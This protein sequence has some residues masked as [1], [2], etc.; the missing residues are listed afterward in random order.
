MRFHSHF[1]RWQ[2]LL[3]GA[4]LTCALLL[5]LRPKSSGALPKPEPLSFKTITAPNP[6][7]KWAT[8]GVLISAK[9]AT[10]AAGFARYAA[11]QLTK[12]GS[13]TH[14]S[15]FVFTNPN[16][17]AAFKQFQGPRRGRPLLIADFAKL[18][19]IW[20]KTPV[21]YEKAGTSERIL[22]PSKKPLTWWRS[23]I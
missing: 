19:P 22:L 12:S 4:A 23:L 20:S 17:A 7:L 1:L 15:V 9:N 18:T 10:Q 5:L 16:D 6:K 8:V 13:W 11:T 2:T 14:I 3:A 21:Y